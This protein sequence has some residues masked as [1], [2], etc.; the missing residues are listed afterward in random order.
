MHKQQA[1]ARAGWLRRLWHDDCGAV[2]GSEWLMIATVLVL[3]LIPGLV[4]IRQGALEGLFD[5]AH[6]TAALDQS[7]S[8]SGQRLDYG[9][10]DRN[11]HPNFDLWTTRTHTWSNGDRTAPAAAWPGGGHPDRWGRPVWNSWD[12][13]RWEYWGA[14]AETAGSQFIKLPPGPARLGPIAPALEPGAPA[15]P[16]AEDVSPPCG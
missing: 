9:C 1:P 15:M 6:A 8:F 10:W 16:R 2:I 7:Y 5:F 14:G 12:P 3:G 13:Y 11:P 4:L